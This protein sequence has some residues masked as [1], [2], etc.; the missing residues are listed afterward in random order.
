MAPPTT[1][2]SSNPWAEDVDQSVGFFTIFAVNAVFFVAIRDLAL[3]LF[4]QITDEENISSP[5]YAAIPTTSSQ[6]LYTQFVNLYGRLAVLVPLVCIFLVRKVLLTS[7]WKVSRLVDALLAVLLILAIAFP[8]VWIIVRHSTVQYLNK[9]EAR[10]PEVTA[11]FNAFYCNARTTE[12]C[13]YEDLSRN[14]SHLARLVQVFNATGNNGSMT[15]MPTAILNIFLGCQHALIAHKGALSPVQAAFLK[16]SNSSEEVDTWC[17]RFILRTILRLEDGNDLGVIHTPANVND[18][19]FDLFVAAWQSSFALDVVLLGFTS[20]LVLALCWYWMQ[21][22]AAHKRGRFDD[23]SGSLLDIHS[24]DEQLREVKYALAA[25][26]RLN[27]GIK[28]ED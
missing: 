9:I 2:T 27:E 3:L 8:V 10:D 26:S 11:A 16:S 19:K 13:V 20:L 7:H 23:V 18:A 12:M 21:M 4:S 28:K 14:Q 1:T 5:A 22:P 25:A 17:G 15:S 6:E 24:E